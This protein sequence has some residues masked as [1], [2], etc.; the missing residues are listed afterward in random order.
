METTTTTIAEVV[1]FGVY[2]AS[3]NKFFGALAAAGVDT[4]VDIRSRRG[5]RGTEYAFVNSQRLQMQLKSMG[6]RYVHVKELAPTAAVRQAQKREDVRAGVAKRQRDRLGRAFID[7]YERDVLAG[8]DPKGL[9]RRLPADA[10]VIALFCVERAA[11]A[12]HR[13]LVADKLAA[14]WSV[15]VKHIDPWT[16]SSSLAP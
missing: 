8:F 1:T 6:V 10:R 13:S 3:E 15:R 4:F 14:A 16:F 2:G 11:A 7:A 12:C 5:M 9:M